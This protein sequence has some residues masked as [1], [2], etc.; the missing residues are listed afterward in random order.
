VTGGGAAE[1]CF[2]LRITAV[3]RHGFLAIMLA[4]VAAGG[5]WLLNQD[6][7]LDASEEASRSFREALQGQSG[8]DV[9]VEAEDGIR[10]NF[11]EASWDRV[12]QNVAE[13]GNLILVM[14]KIP[15][16][17]YARR[18]RARYRPDSV[19]RI[20]NSELESQGFRLIAQGN[21]L[22]VLKLD[23]ARTRYARSTVAPVAQTPSEEPPVDVGAWENAPASADGAPQYCVTTRQ[24]RLA[25]TAGG[26]SGNNRPATATVCGNAVR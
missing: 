15:H 14:D 11:F 13:Q 1:A 7:R 16:G 3:R 24:A 6:Y 22:V 17:R 8:S 25:A 19:I 12:L 4:G 10:L 23:Q 20:L 21:Y 5:A 2:S 9:P 26:T 18:D